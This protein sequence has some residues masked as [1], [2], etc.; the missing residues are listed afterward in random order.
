[1]STERV[2]YRDVK[3]YA[4]PVKLEE[5]HGPHDGCV[6]LPI[7]VRW[8]SDRFGVNIEDR[9]ERRMAYSALLAE[10]TM[11]DISGLVNRDRLCESWGE[12][13]L[14]QRVRDMWEERFSELAAGAL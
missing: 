1:M 11:Q 12:L 6:D 14:D 2:F 5:L 13:R 3:P 8:L 9:V 7:S 4:V 10:G